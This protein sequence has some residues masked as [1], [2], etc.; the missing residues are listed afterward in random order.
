MITLSPNLQ[1]LLSQPSIEVFSMVRIGNNRYTDFYRN[2]T[3]SNDETF[4]TGGPIFSLEPFRLTTVV[5]KATYTLNM[6]DPTFE[7]GALYENYVGLPVAVRIGV[8]NAGAPLTNIADTIL[9][10]KGFIDNVAYATDTSEVGENL[11]RITC[12]SPMAALDM[13]KP[14]YTSK[15]ALVDLDPDDNSFDH[16]YEG[17]GQIRLKWGKG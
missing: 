14:F 13:A 4:Q 8:V 7:F 17:S 15:D 9:V 10:Y 1:A 11:F 3:L 6:S 16:V 12:A 5:D 2:I